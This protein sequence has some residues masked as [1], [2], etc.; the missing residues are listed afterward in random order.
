MLQES[1]EQYNRALKEGQRWQK[2]AQ[3]AGTPAYLPVLDEQLQETDTSPVE[4]GLLEVP[5]DRIVGTKSAGRVSALAGN[6][7]PLLS[8]NSEFAVKWMHLCDAHLSDVGIREPVRCY[9]YL[10]NFYVQ[11]GNKRVSVLKSY[12]ARRISA[13]VTR[14]VPPF[15]EEDSLKRYYAFLWF[16]ERAGIYDVTFRDPN[17][18]GHLQAALGFDE[19]HIWTEEERRSFLAGYTVFDNACAQCI[20]ADEDVLTAEALL[21]WLEVYGFAEIKA[22]PGTELVK[23]LSSIWPDVLLYPKREEI[24]LRTQPDERERSFLGKLLDAALPEHLKVAFLFGY[25]PKVSPWAEAH[26]KGREYLERCFPSQLTVRTYTAE[27]GDYDAVM[28]QAIDDGAGLIFATTAPM[29]GACRRAAAK[30]PDVKLLN[31]ALSLPYTGVRM[32]YSR[33]HEC[34]YV[35]GALAGAMTEKDTVGYIAN[36]PIY[37]TLA[38]INAFALGV[39][40]TNPRARV[41]LVWSCLPEDP[42]TTLLREGVTVIS[43]REATAPGQTQRGFERGTYKLQQ[44]GSLLPLAMPVWHWGRMYEKIVRCILNGAWSQLEKSKA[45]N[46]W[47]GLDSGV[48]D[49]Q[50][51][52]DLPD[53]V[54][55]L[56]WILKNGVTDGSIAPFRTRILDQ[57]GFERNNG[58]RDLSPEEILTMDW[59]CDNVDGEIP[60][61]EQLTPVSK[62]IVRLLGLYREKLPPEKEAKQL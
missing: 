17:D 10:G 60:P 55:S 28:Q 33:I 2:A 14:L 21:V 54:C 9:E 50:L 36:Y 51:G 3:A 15:R 41:K 5:I 52:E 49:V 8:P 6:F 46:Y 25:S 35:T 16:Y 7:M 47:W 27:K 32:Y 12:G 13:Y 31:C 59:L 48:L 44:D 24:T 53:G 43:N 23:K 11:E 37:G 20:T 22:T 45:I 40:L 61:F 42:V 19:G 57:N 58:L 34:K 1:L 18:Y 30:H 38:S 29:I 62:E 4:L 39:R 56:G 26:D